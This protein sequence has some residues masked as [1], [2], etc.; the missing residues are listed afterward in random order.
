V[1]VV[2]GDDVWTRRLASDRIEAAVAS[3]LADGWLDDRAPAVVV[4]DLDHLRGR[5]DRLAAVFPTGTLHAIAIKANPEVEILRRVASAGHGLEAA[6]WEEV[7]LGLAAGCPAAR[8]VFDSPAKTRT[9]LRE[10]LALGVRIN[11]DNLD[12][13][14]RIDEIGPS[15]GAEIG[16][17]VNPQVGLGQIT[18]LSVAD[19][20]SRFGLPWGTDPTELV[21]VFRR[22]PWL[23]GL[24]AHVGSQGVDLSQL[25]LAAR[26]LAGLREAI[27]AATEP[28]RIRS[29]DIGGGLPADYGQGGPP[30]P[31][32]GDYAEELRRQAPTLMTGEVQLVTEFGRAVQTGCGFAVSRV[33]YVK[34][35]GDRQLATLHVGADLLLR[36]AY[37]PDVWPHALTVLDKNGRPKAGALEPWTLVGPLCFAGDVIAEA[38]ALPPIAPGDLVVIH[39]IGAYTM[40]MWSAHCSRRRPPVLGLQSAT[41][42]LQLLAPRRNATAD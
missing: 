41:T 27:D 32:V 1:E 10:A 20:R 3:A 34:R 7:Q 38:R 9:E 23:V 29:V 6:S 17:R 40:G 21:S 33:E 18:M 31:D 8:I 39:D 16:L 2:N 30:P 4:H 5:L 24:H 22:H 13:L 28:R 14:A 19:V 25:L 36:T 11:A 15:P 35:A 42:R 37:Q 26:R 12:E